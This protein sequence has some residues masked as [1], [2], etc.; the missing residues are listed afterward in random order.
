MVNEKSAV[1]YVQKK[2]KT[3]Y[4]CR[5]HATHSYFTPKKFPLLTAEDEGKVSSR[6][7]ENGYILEPENLL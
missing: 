2:G 6:Y 3:T 7:F 4:P 1:G 5:R